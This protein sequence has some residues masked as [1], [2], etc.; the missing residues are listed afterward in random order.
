MV[1]PLPIIYAPN[2]IFRQKAKAVD[3]VNDKVREVVAQMFATL[4][5][6]HAIGIG[7]N[8]VGVLQRIVVIKLREDE[9]RYALINPEIKW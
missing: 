8:M 2:P 5:A 1:A 4:E 7:A 3:N 6:E 9:T